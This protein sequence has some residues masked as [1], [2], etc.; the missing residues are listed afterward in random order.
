MATTGSMPNCDAVAADEIAMSASC[1][2]VGSGMTAQSP[3]TSTR[4]AS[5]IRN[6][7]ETTE[8][9]GRVLMISNAG[10]MVWAVVCA[11]PETIP[12]ARP[13]CTIIV[14]KYDGSVT[15]SAAWSMVMPLWERSFA[16]SCANRCRSTSSKGLST[17]AADRS[18]PSSI[19][20]DRTSNGSPRIVRRA[21]PRLSSVAAAL[22]MRSSS[23][24]GST[25]CLSAA[26]ARSTRSYSNMSGVTTSRRA[27]VEA[28]EQRIRIHMAFEER[29]RGVVFALRVRR[30]PPAGVRDADGG[31]ER[32]E[33]GLDDRQRSS[34][35]RPAAARWARAARS[36]RSARCPRWRGRCRMR[37]PSAP[38]AAPPCGRPGRRPPTPRSA[39]AGRCSST[40]RRRRRRG[41]PAR[42]E[43]HRPRSARRP[44]RSM[45]DRTLGATRNGSSGIAHTGT[46]SP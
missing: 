43:P 35:G 44:S 5:A 46:P 9:P 4:S 22:R 32:A 2:A 34:R 1:S 23:P 27:D 6:T 19:A 18:R 37:S 31:V 33:L 8:T 25:M 11:A 10:R 7:L 20:R 45:I 24:S 30:E 15:V 26:R 29:E 12:S 40:C 42:A 28:R 21:T 14:P 16:Y 39:A 36:R 41:P 3:Y 17:S 38:R 13:R